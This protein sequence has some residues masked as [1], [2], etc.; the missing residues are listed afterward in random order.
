MRNSAQRMRKKM[1]IKFTYFID[2]LG[3]VEQEVSPHPLTE[4]YVTV[5]RHTALLIQSFALW[6]KAMLP[7]CK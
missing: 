2:C 3:R 5:S 1:W 6:R 7:M 4:P